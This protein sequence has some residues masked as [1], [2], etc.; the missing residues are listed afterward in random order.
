MVPSYWTITEEPCMMFSIQYHDKPRKIL[1][2][3]PAKTYVLPPHRQWQVQKHH[4]PNMPT[5][6]P[7]IAKPSPAVQ[8]DAHAFKQLVLHMYWVNNTINQL[9]THRIHPTEEFPDDLEV[10]LVHYVE[11]KLIMTENGVGSR[12]L[13]TPEYITAHFPE[14]YARDAQFKPENIPTYKGDIPPLQQ[15]P[16]INEFKNEYVKIILGDDGI[17]NYD[18]TGATESLAHTTAAFGKHKK[19]YDCTHPQDNVTTYTEKI[20]RWIGTYKDYQT[21]LCP[22]GKTRFPPTIIVTVVDTGK[23]FFTNQST[24]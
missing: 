4:F 8:K 7:D 2:A 16:T 18:E 9:M 14:H 11:Q 12:H 24:V 21:Y 17:Y 20:K 1:I 6:R 22:D 3:H 13:P 23:A 19:L 15:Q 5:Y 10:L